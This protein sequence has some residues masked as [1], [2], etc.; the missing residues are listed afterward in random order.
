MKN[1]LALSLLLVSGLAQANCA[2][3]E[4]L[5]LRSV[6]SKIFKKVPVKDQGNYGLCYAYAGTTLVDFFRLKDP[7]AKNTNISPLEAGLVSTLYADG[8][9]EVGGDICDVVN[10]IS[11][12]GKACTDSVVGKETRFQDVGINFHTQIVQTVF[13]PYITRAEVFKSVPAEKFKSRQGLTSLQ[14]KYVSRFDQF[15]KSLQIDF[16]RRALAGVILPNA[17]EI[18]SFAQKIHMENKYNL[19]APSFTLLLVK[20]LCGKSTISVPK[21][22]CQTQTG[23]PETMVGDLDHE[24]S[25]K[26]P[27]GI[28]YCS[29]ILTNKSASGME[30]G[31]PKSNCAL[32]ASVVVGRKSD[33]S[34]RCHYLIRNSWG[35]NAKYDWPT[36]EGDIWVSEYILKRNLLKVHTIQ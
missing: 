10:S 13:M 23:S 3:G 5:D 31:K 22:S 25:A 12:K 15:Y 19:L 18:F 29:V 27:V 21:L 28:S 14:K 16:N 6:H 24:L 33:S 11:N 20:K 34:G 26:S 30:Y 2:S 17:A 8:D 1:F 35:S 32:H 7:E 9:S 4:Y 36:S